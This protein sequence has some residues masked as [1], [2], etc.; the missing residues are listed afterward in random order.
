MAA[1]EVVQGDHVVVAAQVV[2][3]VVVVHASLVVAEETHI[4]NSLQMTGTLKTQIMILVW[5]LTGKEEM[6]VLK[7]KVTSLKLDFLSRRWL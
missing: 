7:N 4:P 5:K 3:V 1:V 6:T 2:P